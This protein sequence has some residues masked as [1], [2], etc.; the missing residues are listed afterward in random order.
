MWLLVGGAHLSCQELDHGNH[1]QGV[2]NEHGDNSQEGDNT[3]TV[4]Q[5]GVEAAVRGPHVGEGGDGQGGAE[6]D[7]GR[8][9]KQVAAGGESQD[10]C[11]QTCSDHADAGHND[12]GEPG[13]DRGARVLED[14]GHVEHHGGHPRQLGHQVQDTRTWERPQER[15]GS[16]HPEQ[17]QQSLLLGLVSLLFDFLV[18]ALDDL[19]NLLGD[20]IL[21]TPVPLKACPAL[22]LPVVLHQPVGRLPAAPHG[23]RE[24]EGA[25]GADP[26]SCPPVKQEAQEVHLGDPERQE[27]GR[28]HAKAA[29]PVRV[30]DLRDKHPHAGVGR[31]DGQ[32]WNEPRE[33]DDGYRGRH[34]DQAPGEE[35]REPGN[36]CNLPPSKLGGEAASDYAGGQAGD[37]V[38]GRDPWGLLEPDPKSG[39]WLRL[40]L[41]NEGGGEANQAARVEGDQGRGQGAQALE[42]EIDI[43]LTGKCCFVFRLCLK[44]ILQDKVTPGHSA[45]NTCALHVMLEESYCK[46]HQHSVL[47]IK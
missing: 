23:D 9:D 8:E 43:T 13:V 24:E 10:K 14:V 22:L 2:A 6:D 28:H 26:A 31:A 37:E 39:V 33:E 11:G 25:E 5:A 45:L 32:R 47:A 17:S 12:G 3:Q 20:V 35:E 21:R 34:R 15:L 4:L 29:A 7:H 19:L 18:L 42:V 1:P 44:S 16:H 36:H 38:E 40:Q 41:R 30:R 27:D 46:M